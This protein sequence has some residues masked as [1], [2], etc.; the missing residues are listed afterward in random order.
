MI[1]KI[2]QIMRQYLWM[3]FELTGV[4]T[5]K[6]VFHGYLDEAEEV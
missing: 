3:D 5:S 6:V 4:S 1:K 2:N